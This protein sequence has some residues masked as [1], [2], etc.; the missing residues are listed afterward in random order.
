[1]QI[2]VVVLLV[3]TAAPFWLEMYG[4]CYMLHHVVMPIS[5]KT[6]KQSAGLFY[7]GDSWRTAG[8]SFRHFTIQC[9]P[10]CF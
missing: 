5:D 8:K 9:T 7:H 3:V 6:G 2:A 10:F 4:T 1:M